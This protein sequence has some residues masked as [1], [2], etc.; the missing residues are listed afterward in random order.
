MSLAEVILIIN[1]SVSKILRSN[2]YKSVLKRAFITRE[3]T[4]MI[5]TIVALKNIESLSYGSK[6][7]ASIIKTSSLFRNIIFCCLYLNISCQFSAISS[8]EYFII[9]SI[10]VK[11]SLPIFKNSRPIVYCVNI[12]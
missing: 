6:V 2:P 8:T 3:E 10:S 5:S 11:N 1:K 12:L 9:C 4:L 7:I